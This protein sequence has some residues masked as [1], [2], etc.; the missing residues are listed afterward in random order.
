MQKKAFDSVNWAFLYKVLEKIG[1]NEESVNCIR[2]VYQ[3]LMARI[4]I[5]GSLTN[6]FNLE[7]GRR[8]GCCL[9]PSLFVLFVEPLAQMIRQ[10]GEIK[11]VFGQEEHK[12]LIFLKQPNESFPKI[13]ELLENYGIYSGYKINV[14]KHRF[15]Q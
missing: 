1:F 12:I 8:Q 9:S 14:K 2:S 7:R 3:E 13:M 15:C 6:Q 10:E 4:R 11:G 5:N